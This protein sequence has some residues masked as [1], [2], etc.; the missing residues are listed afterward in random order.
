MPI[1]SSQFVNILDEP[2]PTDIF[3]NEASKIQISVK[4]PM[5]FAIAEAES[6]RGGK[7]GMEVGV[8]RERILVSM[9]RHYFGPDNVNSDLPTT[10]PETD[11][12][13]CDI[14]ISIKTIT[15][16]SQEFRGSG[17]KIVWTVDKDSV[18]EFVKTYKPSADLLFSDISWNHTNRGLFYIPQSVQE[19]TQTR[20]GSE[21]YVKRHRLGT[22]PRGVEYS[23]EAMHMMLNHQDTMSMKIKWERPT[24][25]FN[26]YERWDSYWATT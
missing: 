9:F 24:D 16:T 10:E 5:L 1:I 4:L 2:H 26:V 7:I 20:L 23:R 21:G 11:V 15:Y 17:V 18:D 8:M 6:K 22:N 3:I 25:T 12:V 13:V 14:S 19:Y